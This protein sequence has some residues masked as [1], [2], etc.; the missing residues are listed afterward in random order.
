[1]YAKRWWVRTLGVLYPV[2]TTLVVMATGNHYLLDAL[3]GAVVMAAGAGL[4][5]LLRHRT[6]GPLVPQDTLQEVV[7]GRSRAAVRAAVAAASGSHV[8]PHET[9]RHETDV[10]SAHPAER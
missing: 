8:R 1:M 6:K 3:A 2:T 10:V 9:V 4:M 7:A 5:L